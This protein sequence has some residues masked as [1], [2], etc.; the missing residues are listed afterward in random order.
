MNR[1]VRKHRHHKGA[2]HKDDSQSGRSS[3]HMH[4]SSTTQP[5]VPP[6][7]MPQHPNKRHRTV[8][9]SHPLATAPLPFPSDASA[10]ESSSEAT[11]TH[12][13]Q[14]TSEPATAVV[15]TIM[16]LNWA[17]GRAG[18][19]YYTHEFHEL[20]MMDDV[21]ESSTLEIIR[22]LI[23]QIAPQTIIVPQDSDELTSLIDGLRGGHNDIQT[24]LLPAKTFACAHGRYSL[25]SWFIQQRESHQQQQ[26]QQAKSRYQESA[27][28]GSMEASS[29]AEGASLPMATDVYCD[30]PHDGQRR[31]AYLQLSC[32]VDL[33]SQVSVGCAGA[34]LNYLEQ[35][36]D[37]SNRPI[38]SRFDN[39]TSFQALLLRSF[40]SEQCMQISKESQKSLCIFEKDLHPNAHQKRG[41][42]SLS[43]FGLLNHTVTPIG[44]HL[45]KSWVLRPS[46]D[47]NVI[48]AR[49]DAV[50]YFS[51]PDTVQFSKELGTQLK[52]IKNIAR[53]ISMIKEHRA[54]PTEWHQLLEFVYYSIRIYSSFAGGRDQTD[55]AIIMK[56]LN[57][58]DTGILRNVG[59]AIDEVLDFHQSKIE[60][61]LVVKDNYDADLDHLRE[62][63]SGLDAILLSV[64]QEISYNMSPNIAP[65]C[66][67]VY[68]PQL[69]YLIT[70]PIHLEYS[71]DPRWGFEL[72]F[73]TAENLYFKD[74]KTKELDEV[75]GD[76]HA[77]IIDKE[78]ELVHY[79]SDQLLA[80]SQNL[81]VM[82]DVCAELDSLLALAKAAAL[83]NYIKPE[84]TLDN[85]LVIIQGRH[86]LQELAVDVFIANDTY[87]VGGRA[88]T[89]S[90]VSSA[91]DSITNANSVALLTGANFS[92][93]SVYLRQIGLITYMAHIGSFVPAAQAII[94]ITDKI[95]TCIQTVETVSKLQSAFAL[96]IQQ[97]SQAVHYATDRSLVL[98]DEFGN[99][100]ESTDGAALLCATLGYF[101][102][103]GN[104]CPKILA[105]THFHELI[106]RQIITPE[107]NR[108]TFLTMEILNA[109]VTGENSETM[110]EV[111][112]LYK[113]V[114]GSQ[115]RNSYGAWCAS[116][117]GV[118]TQIV[119]RALDLSSIIYS[120]QMI[121]PEY[122]EEEEREFEAIE[123][124]A[125]KLMLVDKEEET[126]KALVDELVQ[127]MLE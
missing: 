96:D 41:K 43:L 83:H 30:D 107:D 6:E 25:V 13:Q 55:I 86:P 77:M 9:S 5:L 85:Q 109:Q 72:Q 37:T 101:L 98:M 1:T 12:D 38:G 3:L 110:D 61:R 76:I 52:H 4:N 27:T 31:Q 46:L 89:P 79:L 123:A 22:S 81:L 10:T 99:G 39:G 75:L 16:A 92:G 19:A 60:G 36:E 106:S 21:V 124:V 23:D 20:Y 2:A 18:C 40:S 8:G 127:L 64:S 66:N 111:V 54:S 119:R 15:T 48:R 90:R 108:I 117:A 45:L 17:K 68:F 102:Y 62:T 58:I 91:S 47:I 113:V 100:T 114:P 116:I 71:I 35:L 105:I 74:V 14:I 44:H 78:I 63:Y 112:F 49:Q 69:G 59:T 24:Q 84:M 33:D 82:A 122:S 70:L 80:Y 104:L 67:V 29:S 95:F 94:G 87:L 73:K 103:K 42:E 28:V 34:L 118:P 125:R 57:T 51:A 97:L 53:I 115:A 93:K 7:P 50:G 26:K 88:A 121:T 65:L 56:I 126:E 11:N 32:Y 120:A